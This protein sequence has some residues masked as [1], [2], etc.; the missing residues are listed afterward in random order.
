MKPAPS[1]TV[2]FGR[3]TA[4]AIAAFWGLPPS[5]GHAQAPEASTGKP[6]SGPLTLQGPGPGILT[7]RPSILAVRTDDPPSI[8]GRLDDAVWRTAARV[9]EFVQQRPRE[10]AP[11]T[12]RTEIYIAYDSRNLYFGIYAHYSDPRLVRAN[13]VDRDQIE[14]DDTVQLF[15]DPFLDQQR[16]YVFSVNGYGVQGDRLIGSRPGGDESW[17]A[18][19]GST[20]RLVED[21]WTAEL[22]IPFKS[23][24]YPA[25]RGGE[26]HCWGFQIQRDIESKNESVVWAPVSRDIPGLLRQMGVL[27]GLTNLS[28]SRNV[29]LLPTITAIQVGNLDRTT[30][31]YATQDVEEGGINVKYGITPNLTLDF[32][33]NPDFSQIESDRPQIEVNQRF[34]LQYPELRP[35]F[36]EGQE[37]FRIMGTQAVHTRTIVDP[38]YG[39]KLTGK[40]GKT[41]L[42]IVVANDEAPGKV[43][44]PNDPAFGKSAQFVLGRVRYDFYSESY[45]GAIVTDREFLDSH[46]RLTGF[47]GNFRLGRNH[48]V[49]FSGM[50]TDRQDQAGLQRTGHMFDAHF[51]KEGRNLSYMVL[52][53]EIN[54]DFQTDAG[55]IRRVDLKNTMGNVSYRWW[56]E[57]WVINWGPRINYDRNYDFQGVLQD[58]G[59]EASLNAQFARNMGMNVQITRDMERF[60]GI[61]FWKTRYSFGGG[62]NTSRRISFGGRFSAGDQIRFVADP[63]LG[64]STESNLNMTLRPVSR[65][66]SEINVN[67]SRLTDPRDASEVFNVKI[68]RSL[69]VY[70]FTERLL[71][72][73]ITEY[74]TFARALAG[75]LLFTYRVNAGTVFYAGYDDHLEESAKINSLLF[76]GTSY[77]RTNRAIFAKLQYLFRL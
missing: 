36:L 54:P 58:E 37:I 65:L 49:G 63:F 16:G 48:R 24:R 59:M 72:R 5:V 53:R 14:R 28:R 73:N 69:T 47:D 10:G 45:L 56:P 66:Q 31:A 68:V 17:D 40:V 42:G 4:I 23:L 76:P 29:E 60:G 22:A 7:G 71:V 34:P 46:S 70:Q 64:S 21:G 41:A 35:F 62:M 51:R 26:L 3:L 44:S 32:S 2:W 67:T 61:N 33:Y 11:A 38:Q 74:N 8:D 43:G 6:V 9:T 55:F 50:V 27:D 30:G 75:N 52:H 20:G 1:A 57:S 18:L 15:F 25:R 12:E 13:H 19:F 77:R 39:V